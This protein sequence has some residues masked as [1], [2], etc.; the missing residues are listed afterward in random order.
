VA[1]KPGITVCEGLKEVGV[2]DTVAFVTGGVATVLV[3]PSAIGYAA[4]VKVSSW[5]D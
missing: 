5:F 4:A 3:T 1:G 2:N